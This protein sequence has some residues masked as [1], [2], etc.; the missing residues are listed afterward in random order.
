MADAVGQ[1]ARYLAELRKLRPACA[2]EEEEEFGKCA[3]VEEQALQ[4]ALADAQARIMLIAAQIATTVT[5]MRTR[6]YELV[7]AIIPDPS[8]G[9]QK[10]LQQLYDSLKQVDEDIQ[11]SMD[12]GS[13]RKESLSDED[14]HAIINKLSL[15]REIQVKWR[16]LTEKAVGTYVDQLK[17]RNVNF[18]AA[19]EAGMLTAREIMAN[20]LL[21]DSL[22]EQSA[23]KIR[24]FMDTYNYFISG[25]EK[26]VSA[27]IEA[28][29]TWQMDIHRAIHM[30]LA[31]K[32][33]LR[34]HQLIIGALLSPKAAKD[35]PRR[36]LVYHD[37]GT[38]KTCTAFAAIRAFY[39]EAERLGKTY[40]IM[41]GLPNFALYEKWKADIDPKPNTG[42]RYPVVK[43]INEHVVQSSK[44]AIITLSGN[45]GSVELYFH[46]YTVQEPDRKSWLTPE[47]AD[48][49]IVDEAHNIADKRNLSA[50]YGGNKNA[51]E[52]GRRWV[53]GVDS[54]RGKQSATGVYRM[55]LLTGTP[56]MALLVSDE[57]ATPTSKIDLSDDDQKELDDL[58]VLLT[59]VHS[60]AQ[61]KLLPLTQYFEKRTG[62]DENGKPETY[63]VWKDKPAFMEATKHSVSF[64]SYINKPSVYPRLAARCGRTISYPADEEQSLGR[65]CDYEFVPG[66][67]SVEELEGKLEDLELTA[68]RKKDYGNWRPSYVYVPLGSTP[69]ERG[70]S[71]AAAK[72]PRS[73][74]FASRNVAKPSSFDLKKLDNVPREQRFI[75][76]Q[77]TLPNKAVA[78]GAMID[79]LEERDGA[80]AGKHFVFSLGRSFATGPSGVVF[81]LKSKG[82]QFIDPAQ[83]VGGIES[84]AEP[85]EVS[86]PDLRKDHD[87]KNKIMEA[88]KE[89]WYATHQ[90]AKRF[91]YLGKAGSGGYELNPLELPLIKS[92]VPLLFNDPR[93]WDGSYI[94]IFVGSVMESKE[95]L[96]LYDVLYEHFLDPPPNRNWYQQAQGRALRYNGHKNRNTKLG[97]PADAD[98]N[99]P[100]GGTVEVFVYRWTTGGPDGAETVLKLG[101]THPSRYEMVTD[102]IRSNAIDCR[103][104]RSVTGIHCYGDPEEI[105]EVGEAS[106]DDQ[107]LRVDVDNKPSK[108]KTGVFYV[109]TSQFNEREERILRRLQALQ[110]RYDP[111]RVFD[112]FSF[113][114]ATNTYDYIPTTVDR[115][116]LPEQI[117]QIL[118]R[119]GAPNQLNVETASYY[120]AS[121][122]LAKGNPDWLGIL[123]EAHA[124]ALGNLLLKRQAAHA[125][126]A[127]QMAAVERRLRL[128]A[129]V[130]YALQ[131]VPALAE[132]PL[133]NLPL[134]FDQSRSITL[135]SPDELEQIR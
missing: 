55:L 22:Q 119:P 61:P 108:A 76:E 74:G 87:D 71:T 115:A 28:E 66:S 104:N 111:M 99:I 54:S 90:P 96:D 31:K 102:A 33:G 15:N 51:Q 6:T 135:P 32:Y 44:Q 105:A 98:G 62:T 130:S 50:Q 117:R 79:F 34:D 16:D 123:T 49:V 5:T 3:G 27:P 113:D 4:N 75:K 23:R 47:K 126:S 69:V 85:F 103:D 131:A 13:L 45:K 81:E 100:G 63:Y 72:P 125:L 48:M 41:I 12:Y 89:N 14:A 24:E 53:F 118:Q 21:W 18:G 109:L 8:V 29:S 17:K 107:F 2:T 52:F 25:G 116:A 36:L 93:N 65:A 112:R 39:D 95:G 121:R 57:T 38:G 84:A 11:K 128:D 106:P 58:F 10:E 26:V 43:K 97:M 114:F 92:A 56:G 127:T 68:R 133:H 40:R 35:A 120:V 42:C 80:N 60:D 59:A 37:V 46:R 88:Y 101:A 9:M 70:S 19:S 20:N 129:L 86:I 1:R 122:I 83:I 73:G 64:F 77:K 124:T 82:Y 7:S 78:L 67:K 110:G 132:L 91:V 30:E 94:K 134:Y